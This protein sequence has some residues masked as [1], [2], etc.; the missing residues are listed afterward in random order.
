MGKMKQVAA[1]RDSH[2]VVDTANGLKIVVA[3][4]RNFYFGEYAVQFV[5]SKESCK[6]EMKRLK[7]MEKEYN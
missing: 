1:G 7:D 5:G 4:Q 3:N 6:T 2:M